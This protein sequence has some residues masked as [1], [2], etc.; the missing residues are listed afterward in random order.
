MFRA[1]LICLLA[2]A[3]TGPTGC[4]KVD[5][6]PKVAPGTA[7]GKVIEV[8]GAVTATRGGPA[9]LLAVGDSVSP[10]DTVVTAAD[11]SVRV[12]LFHNHAKLQLTQ[13]ASTR[14]DG[15]LA[16]ELSASEVAALPAGQVTVAAGQ[17]GERSAAETS[18][19]MVKGS[20]VAPTT[21]TT[22]APPAIEPVAEPTTSAADPALTPLRVAAT[23]D[24]KDRKLDPVSA[25]KR[26][27]SPPP[28][29]PPPPR[30]QPQTPTLG[31]TG[32]GGGGGG[33][34]TPSRTAVPPRTEQP[35]PPNPGEESE[36][37]DDGGDK[38]RRTPGA[39]ALTVD[40]QLAPSRAKLRTCLVS[41]VTKLTIVVTVTS[42]RPTIQVKGDATATTQACVQGVIEGLRLGAVD[43]TA[44]IVITP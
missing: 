9:R 14:I 5:G 37:D 1:L 7:V 10:D 6:P 31:S 3:A 21:P 12:E 40:A 29:P 8:Q 17:V 2:A 15:S 25:P 23:A 16:W 43:G 26:K 41:G 28:P 32:G 30:I 44:T 39:P 24:R 36:Q 34:G 18:N 11:A 33:G 42:K 19:T 22:P 13:G 38:G 35:S 20:P 27:A 4:S